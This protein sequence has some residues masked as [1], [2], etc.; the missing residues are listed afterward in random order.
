M[1]PHFTRFIICM[2][3]AL[4]VYYYQYIYER[5]MFPHL[6]QHCELSVFFFSLVLRALS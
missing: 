2:D 3:L 1:Q 6:Q 4:L 5:D